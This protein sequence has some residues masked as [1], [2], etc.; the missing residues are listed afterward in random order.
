MTDESPLTDDWIAPRIEALKSLELTPR[1]R[2]VRRL[3][4]A[5]REVIDH[6][7]T[8][9]AGEQQLA[10]AADELE[11]L[12]ATLR[13][14]PKGVSYLG[15]AEAA[16]AG[17]E[18]GGLTPGDLEWYSFFD[19]S[20]IIGLANPL[21]PPMVMDFDEERVRGRVC[22][23]AAYEGPP[24][25]VHGGYVAAIF[26]ELLGSAQNLSGDGGMTAHL[27]VDYRSPTPLHVELELEAW[28]ERKEGRKIYTRGT[29]HANG[30]LTAEADALFIAFDK[31]KFKALLDARN[32]SSTDPED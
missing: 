23:G 18:T 19:H 9:S 3:A 20:P 5:M 17:Q 24:G 25:C 29:I 13:E 4:T 16:N 26:D 15:F 2:E 32:E 6:L 12:A 11:E 27:G 31:E 14:L 7:V 8:T 22:F 28:L 30:V 1:R 10:R 21:S